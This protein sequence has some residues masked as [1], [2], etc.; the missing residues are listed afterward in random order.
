MPI[1]TSP[2]LDVV[3]QR[4]AHLPPPV[5]VFNKSHSGSRVL[6]ALLSSAGIFMGA[7]RN[8]SGDS[9]DVL[10]LVTALV[11]DYYPDY[12]PLWAPDRAPDRALASL[13]AHAF[14]RHLDGYGAGAMRP[15][16][17]K[18]CEGTFII[19][20]LD[21]CFP[22]ARYI[23]LIRDGR[24]VAFA[25]HHGPTDDWWRKIYFDTDRIRTV[26][27]L[28]LTGASYRRRSHLFNALHWLNAVTAGRHFGMM[29][30]DRCLEVRYEDLCMDFDRTAR[31]VLAFAGAPLIDAALSELEPTIRATAIGKFRS[32]PRHD[33][34]EATALM[35]PLL[36]SLGYLS[37]DPETSVLR[38]WPFRTAERIMSRWTRR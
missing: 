14:E 9:L 2:T 11:R 37:E 34:R 6:S 31:R 24:D 12:A 29:L 22:D 4:F 8:E 13:A 20:A 35:K 36:L 21:Y 16:G 38:R 3:R 32:K 7:H 33:V 10:D 18:L 26:Q 28:P 1:G 5:I 25:N 23:H 17:W 19:P 30:R 27:G 15:W